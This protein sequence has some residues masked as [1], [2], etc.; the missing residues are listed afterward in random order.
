MPIFAI[1]VHSPDPEILQE[2]KAVLE[3]VAEVVPHLLESRRDDRFNAVVE[4]LTPDINLSPTRL[5]EAEM[6]AAAIT[7]ILES[8]DLVTAADIAR[9]AG[10]SS[11]N[12]SSQ[13]NRWK[14]AGLFFAVPHKGADYFPL[15]AL[16][17][18]NGYKPYPVVSKVLSALKN[19]DAWGNAF[20]FASL[21]GYLGGKRPQDLLATD[22]ERV[23]GAAE[24]EAVGLQHG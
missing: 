2:T 1:P 14:K 23:L 11:S 20:W 16:D 22:P 4:A 10:Y 3:R 18:Q 12:P 7:K 21:N 13:P 24:D 17:P 19:K 6:K 15:Y 9:L 5:I 8:G